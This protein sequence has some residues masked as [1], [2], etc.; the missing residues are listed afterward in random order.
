VPGDYDKNGTVDAA[1][2][3]VWRIPRG[4][5]V[6]AFAGADGD[7]SGMIDQPD[8]EFWRARFG[9]ALPAGAGAAGSLP[10]PEAT[11]GALLFASAICLAARSR[12]TAFARHP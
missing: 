7:G 3:V 4:Q 5:S 12:R 9:N 6:S 2:Y 1:D 10:V 11:T 8:Y